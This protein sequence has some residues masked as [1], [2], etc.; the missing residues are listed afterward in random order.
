M[1]VW[2]IWMSTDQSDDGK[3]GIL[4]ADLDEESS[5]DLNLAD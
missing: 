2:M 5:L 4:E 1:A 3:E